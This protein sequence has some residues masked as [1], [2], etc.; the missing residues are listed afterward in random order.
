M[1]NKNIIYNIIAASIIAAS[2]VYG[3]FMLRNSYIRL[4]ESVKDFGLSLAFY[5]CKMFSIPYT[6]TPTVTA[7]P[8]VLFADALPFAAADIIPIIKKLWLNLISGQNM[9]NYT[10]LLFSNI[11][12]VFTAFLIIIVIDFSL[13]IIY[14]INISEINKKYNH[15]TLPLRVF[16]TV[17]NVTYQPIKKFIINFAEFLKQ[18]KYYLNIF[19]FIWLCNTNIIST[20]FALAAFILY[21]IPSFDIS[22]LI[23]QC[24]KLLI[25]LTLILTAIPIVLWLAVGI[26]IF[27]LNRK[28]KGYENLEKLEAKNETIVSDLPIVIYIDGTMAKGKTTDLTDISITLE[29]LFRMKAQELIINNSL[30]FP[31]FPWI[32]LENEIKNGIEEHKI[33]T[34]ATCKKFI[35][36]K[37]AFFLKN[38][39]ETNIFGY[40]FKR[41]P[42]TYNDG[43]EIKSIWDI[44]INYT[45]LYFIYIAET[46]LII[47]NYSIRDDDNL[48]SLGNFPKRDNEL[49]RRDP[50]EQRL[51]SKHCVIMDYDALRYGKIM[52]E[53]N[54]NKD[55]LEFGVCVISEADKE[56]GNQFDRNGKKDDPNCNRANDGF[57]RGLK[58]HRHSA[59]IDGFCFF[60]LLMDGQRDQSINSDMRELATLLHIKDRKNEKLAMP[61]FMYEEW[62]YETLK[63]KFI[64][65]YTEYRFR[66]GDNT[67]FMHLYKNIFAA[68]NNYHEKITNTF[69]YLTLTEE[70]EAGTKKW[71]TNQIKYYLLKKK[72]YSARFSSD[73]FSGFFEYKALKSKVGINDQARYSGK[74]ATISELNKQGSFFVGESINSFFGTQSN[75]NP[76]VKAKNKKQQSSP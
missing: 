1:K 30:R 36:E 16:K 51:E 17:S 74:T 23:N 31:N 4:F 32:N 18:R 71:G 50:R 11:D 75:E 59:L 67:L 27:D 63:N 33:Y 53:N 69:G 52:K 54:I 25:D 61:N 55:Y 43:L 2:A 65:K 76:T 19:I 6:F 8:N 5:F 70:S 48:I 9:L 7:E 15:D 41:Y 68:V 3:A 20:L 56:F 46:S 60:A 64:D 66:R 47:S 22:C 21:I 73:A 10:L 44:L 12:K 29:R 62:I 42:M 14:K 58:M 39:T 24:H 45:K 13:F 34:L 72:I 26:I 40:D 57:N 28:N 35:K 38:K 49:F 37:H